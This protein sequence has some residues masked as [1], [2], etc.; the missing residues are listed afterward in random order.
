MQAKD[1]LDVG[2]LAVAW[3][4]TKPTLAGA[5]SYIIVNEAYTIGWRER[6]SLKVLNFWRIR[7]CQDAVKEV[8]VPEVFSSVNSSGCVAVFHFRRV[9]RMLEG[10]LHYSWNSYVL[11]SL[12]E[13]IQFLQRT[14]DQHHNLSLGVPR[15]ASSLKAGIVKRIED[16]LIFVKDGLGLVSSVLPREVKVYIVVE[17]YN[18]VGR[19]SL[20][21]IS[22]S[23]FASW[24]L[25]VGSWEA[26]VSL[27][28]SRLY[29]WGS[30]V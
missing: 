24:E 21:F 5:R 17:E 15:F 3:C 1:G 6:R 4:D 13:L 19:M 29:S 27:S 11:F 20:L 14:R 7:G 18:E 26:T 10:P 16:R 22:G 8:R 30:K 25:G 23:H 2:V 9:G 12:D 28:H